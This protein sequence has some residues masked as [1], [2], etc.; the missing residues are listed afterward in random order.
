MFT[1]DADT[2]TH[3][4]SVT[5]TA[6]SATAFV[7]VPSLRTSQYNGRQIEVEADV[8]FYIKVGASGVDATG[9]GT[10]TGGKLPAGVVKIPANQKLGYNLGP[11]VT[12][13]SI[14][15]AGTDGTVTITEG[16]GE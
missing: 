11:S 8:A 2:V 1:I 3:S 4:L 10:A 6:S 14:I 5:S 15:S 16:N 12:H 7:E 9:A 13:F